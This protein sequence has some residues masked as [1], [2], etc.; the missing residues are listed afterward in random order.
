[1]NHYKFSSSLLEIITSL[2]HNDKLEKEWVFR[3]K[4]D[5]A[6]GT[7][8][9]SYKGRDGYLFSKSDKSFAYILR[10]FP[11]TDNASYIVLESCN[12][13]TQLYNMNLDSSKIFRE[14]DD[15]TFLLESY[16]MTVGKGRKKDSVV[17]DMFIS[18]GVKSNEITKIIDDKPDWSKTLI[19]ILEWGIVREKVKQE[20]KNVILIK[21]SDINDEIEDEF[22]D[23]LSLNQILYGPPGTGK[24]YHSINKAIAII[25]T[26][27]DLNQERGIIKDK[28]DELVEAGQIVFTTFHQSMNYED[29][30]EGIKPIKPTSADSP[31][32]Y[33][34]EDGIFKKIVKNAMS[35]YLDIEIEDNPED[36]FDRLYDDFV[37][38][39]LP[40]KGRNQAVFETKRGV[41]MMVVDA[42]EVSIDVKYL[43]SG[44]GKTNEE[45]IT[46]NITKELLKRVSIAGIIPS[47]EINLLED[48]IPII[49]Q[50]NIEIFAV[51]K[52]FYDFAV[53]NKVELDTI[54][55]DSSDLSY[56][57]VKEQFD[58]LD[59]ETVK[60]IPVNNYVLI[61]D[62]INRGNV[63]QIF[64]ELITLIEDNKRLG[65]E[66]AIEVMLPYSKVK[67][68]VP[69][70]LYIVGTMNTADRSVE[71]LD[72][73][74]R[75]RFS[76]EEMPPDYNLEKLNYDLFGFNASLILQTI[77]KRIEK[78]IDRDHAIGHS[79]F[80]GKDK[81]TIVIS[82]Y[83]NIIPLLQEYFFGDY[84]KIGLV[85]GSGFIEEKPE[86]E[87]NEDF[88]AHFVN[89]NPSDYSE[90][91]IYQIVDYREDEDLS[92][93]EMA[94][95]LLMNRK[96]G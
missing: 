11:N 76:F 13:E 78:L 88:F 83:K 22:A 66:E 20:L 69:A 2:E 93:F 26:D 12:T 62:E 56:E 35:D 59:K 85:L 64:G 70:N 18:L 94:I 27:F 81:E 28:F 39:I 46:F 8:G 19:D 10:C 42:N 61:I 36:S 87:N 37:H 72:A 91:I 44:K 90:K 58:L 75:R 84:G 71:A 74:L 77:N 55:C 95:S 4:T 68:G 60:T 80:I 89:E 96:I 29:F 33:K 45:E 6:Y 34:I 32:N 9:G 47:K 92:G 54:F 23:T 53:Q 43:W 57:D 16:I 51:Y 5:T 15:E 41:G 49:G 31:L 65:E 50:N 82:F 24:T 38:N 30:I 1:M 67:F 3:G 17:K 86:D 7:P 48:L 73:A 14:K 25:D 40:F 21:A 79:Y 63:S 52:R